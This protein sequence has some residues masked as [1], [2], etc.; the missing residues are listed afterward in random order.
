MGYSETI[1][2]ILA[3]LGTP[4]GQ[5]WVTIAELKAMAEKLDGG[6]K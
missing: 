4:E 1:A 2:T 3:L 6:K 5:E